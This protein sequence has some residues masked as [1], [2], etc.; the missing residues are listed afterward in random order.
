MNKRI[1]T[2]I[3]SFVL[4]LCLLVPMIPFAAITSDAAASSSVR[5]FKAGSSNYGS[6]SGSSWTKTTTAYEAFAVD[7]VTYLPKAM[8]SLAFNNRTDFVSGVVQTQYNG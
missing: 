3:L 8:V 6:K 1:L 5:Y 2:R 7:G 4:V